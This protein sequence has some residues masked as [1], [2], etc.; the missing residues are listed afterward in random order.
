MTPIG[1]DY[2]IYTLQLNVLP[3]TQQSTQVKNFDVNSLKSP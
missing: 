2:L 1:Y 3:L